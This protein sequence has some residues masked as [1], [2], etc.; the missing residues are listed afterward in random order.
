MEE[1]KEDLNAKTYTIPFEHH[2]LIA[3]KHNTYLDEK[4]KTSKSNSHASVLSAYFPQ[5]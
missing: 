5:Q 4:I 3:K 2:L 1:L